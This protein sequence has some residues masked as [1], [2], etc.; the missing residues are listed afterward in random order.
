M[1]R[2]VSNNNKGGKNK[3]TFLIIFFDPEIVPKMKI[4]E[5]M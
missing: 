2:G 3:N 5:A 4:N 1:F